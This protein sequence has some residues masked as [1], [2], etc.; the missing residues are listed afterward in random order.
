MRSPSSLLQARRRQPRIHYLKE[1]RKDLGGCGNTRAVHYPR[2]DAPADAVIRAFF[3]V[4]P[5]GPP[6][7]WR[8]STSSSALCRTRRLG[9]YIVPIIPDEARTFGMEGMF[10]QYGI[11]SS[12]GQLY[13]PV[14]HATLTRYREARDGVL[15]EEGITEAGAM[16]SFIAAGT[17]Y[18]NLG[19]PIVPFY[20]YYSMFGFQRVGDLIWA[21]ADMRARGF[22]LGGTAGRTTL[23]GEGLQHQDGHSHIAALTVPNVVAYDPAFAYEIALIVQDGIRRMYHNDESVFYYLTLGNENYPME[24]MPE[25]VREGVLKGM[26]RFRKSNLGKSAVK[27]PVHLLGSAAIFHDTL[28]AQQILAEKFGIAAD[29]WSVTSYK[30][31]RR[32]ALEVERHN[33]LHPAAPARKSYLETLLAPEKGVFIAASDY[34]KSLPES[35]QRWVPG[36]LIPLGTDGFGRSENRQSLRRFFEV[37]TENIV[38]ATLA[39]LARRGEIPVDR[40]EKAIKELG[41]D[42]EKPDP[43]RA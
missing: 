2:L 9:K 43:V 26:Y 33:R 17:A 4:P 7:P 40:V 20:I 5:A 38:I 16:S 41:V 15:I 13:E 42:P 39:E 27:S 10:T 18:A 36:G 12:V 30:E 29:V 11:Y 37:D 31:L 8:L 34:Q 22:L 3:K 24:P 6:R 25:G 19:V 1:R 23:A 35:I 28:K 21:A 32:E 14:D